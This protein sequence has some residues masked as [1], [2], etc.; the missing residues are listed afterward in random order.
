[1]AR[2]ALGRCRVVVSTHWGGIPHDVLKYVAG[3][4]VA[5]RDLDLHVSPRT[6]DWGM[7]RLRK[8]WAIYARDT[9]KILKESRHHDV[10]V[11]ATAG[12]PAYVAGLLW[13]ALRFNGSLLLLDPLFPASRR[14]DRILALGL[15]NVSCVICIRQGD[16]DTLYNRF[17]YPPQRCRFVLLPTPLAS[18]PE[19]SNEADPPYIYAAGDTYRD[20]PLL[21]EALKS[22]DFACII[23]TRGVS[24]DQ[25]GLP[26]NLSVRPPVPMAEGRK[27]LQACAVVAIPFQDTQLACGPSIVIDALALGKPVVATDTNGARDY[28]LPGS[29]GLLSPSGDSAAMRANLTALMGDR[30][31]RRDMGRAARRFAEEKLSPD[32]FWASLS[33]II[34]ENSRR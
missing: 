23:S 9:V 28:V 20:W 24:P 7:G 27:L 1:M 2:Q 22:T 34:V 16:I 33:A 4:K 15:R 10:S 19:A 3:Q 26:S 31:R 17:G 32:A 29:T 13:R 30:S 25:P 8:L 11:V 5:P 6:V 14:L 21:L 12:V 18:L